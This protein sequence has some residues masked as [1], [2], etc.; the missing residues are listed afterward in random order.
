MVDKH[1]DYDEQP[2]LQDTNPNAPYYVQTSLGE[3]QIQFIETTDDPDIATEVGGTFCLIN[4]L[5]TV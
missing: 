1:D 2:S 4:Y 3:E 5:P